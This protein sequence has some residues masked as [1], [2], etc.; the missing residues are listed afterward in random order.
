MRSDGCS[1]VGVVVDLHRCGRFDYEASSC[2]VFGL[3]EE[4][5]H[6][7]TSTLGHVRTTPA[8]YV[9]TCHRF[10]F[11]TSTWAIMRILG[12]NYGYIIPENLQGQTAVRVDTVQTVILNLVKPLK[13]CSYYN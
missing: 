10:V 5:F 6:M 3:S 9:E 7:I 4:E 8:E 1:F 11:D 13:N 12:E 2:A